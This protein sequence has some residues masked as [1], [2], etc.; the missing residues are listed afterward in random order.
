MKSFDFQMKSTTSGESLRLWVSNRVPYIVLPF[1]IVFFFC[2]IVLRRLD[3]YIAWLFPQNLSKLINLRV[4]YICVKNCEALSGC[5]YI[6][7]R[8]GDLVNFRLSVL[9]ISS[10]LY[11]E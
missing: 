8:P 9:F 6:F 7:A 4:A 2:F 5:G 10:D 11:P 1:L 3:L